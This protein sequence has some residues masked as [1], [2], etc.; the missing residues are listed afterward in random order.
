[1]NESHLFQQISLY[2]DSQGAL[3]LAKMEPGW[4]SASNKE[5]KKTILAFYTYEVPLAKSNHHLLV[6]LCRLLECG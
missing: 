6:R 5:R 2:Q 3:H 1:M 4:K